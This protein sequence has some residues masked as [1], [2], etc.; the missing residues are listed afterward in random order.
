LF[1]QVCVDGKT[2]TVVFSIQIHFLVAVV[3][4]PVQVMLIA[5]KA[6][7]LRVSGILASG[8]QLT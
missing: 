3:S 8:N 4:S 2:A 1:T 5:P 6:K 7:G